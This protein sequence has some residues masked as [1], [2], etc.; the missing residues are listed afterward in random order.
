MDEQRS[1]AGSANW[2][3]P[4]AVHEAGGQTDCCRLADARVGVDVIGL[5]PAASSPLPVLPSRDAGHSTAYL[6]HRRLLT[7]SS[8]VARSAPL[9]SVLAHVL[10]TAGALLLRRL[11]PRLA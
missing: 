3:W 7:R 11:D 9:R 1:S 10:S 5:H 4:S 8:L 6:R 2:G